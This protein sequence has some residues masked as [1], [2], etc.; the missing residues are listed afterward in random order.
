[1]VIFS[2]WTA[3]KIYVV[4]TLISLSFQCLLCLLIIIWNMIYY[5]IWLILNVYIYGS[6][7][8]VSLQC[9]PSRNTTLLFCVCIYFPCLLISPYGLYLFVFLFRNIL[10][11]CFESIVLHSQKYFLWDINSDSLILKNALWCYIWG[12]LI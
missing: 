11:Y 3:R 4:N 9:L 12:M 1:M 8:F 5:F 6:M 7:E 2:F 10:S